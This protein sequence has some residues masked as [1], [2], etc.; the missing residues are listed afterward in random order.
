MKHT[1]QGILLLLVLS[2]GLLTGCGPV[3]QPAAPTPTRNPAGSPTSTAAP[4]AHP[5]NGVAPPAPTREIPTETKPA[6]TPGDLDFLQKPGPQSFRVMS[7][8]VNWDAIFPP[9]DPENHLFRSAD[10]SAVF[11]DLLAAVRPDIVCLQ[12]INPARDPGQVAE[13]IAGVLNQGGEAGWTAT[14]VRDT[15]IATRFPLFTAGYELAAP[16]YPLGL[17]QAAALIDLPDDLYGDVDVY[18]LCA[19]FKSGGSASDIR[20][21]GSQADVIAHQI[22]DA[23]TPGGAVDLP[24][25]TPLIVLGDFN[26]YDTDPARHLTTLLS[27]DIEDEA[28]YGAD[29]PPDWDGT[30]LADALPSHNG[31]GEIY[32]TWRDDSGPFNPWPLDRI[33]YSDSV[34]AL[35]NAFVLDPALLTETSQEELNLDADDLWLNPAAGVLDH[36]PLVA[37]FA[38]AGSP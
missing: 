9:G 33:L 13:I 10:R 32:Y 21:R 31:L 22:G 34:L 1:S 17:D 38:L 6:S 4:T 2:I 24:E 30:P 14:G 28:R 26:V 18:M 3:V 25:G 35:P 8:N 37:D 11:L 5:T 19:H 29:V 23:I 27:G 16:G 36:L 20:L 7:Y 15:V 12:E